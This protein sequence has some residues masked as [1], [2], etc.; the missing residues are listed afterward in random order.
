[1]LDLYSVWEGI[2]RKKTLEKNLLD[3]KLKRCLNFF[4]LTFFGIGHM[5]GA[6]IFVVTG[7]VTKNVAGTGVILSYILAGIAAFFS[8]LCYA[9]FGARVPKAGSAY[10][11]TYYTMGEF[12]AFFVGWNILLETIIGAASVAKAWS[13]SLDALFGGAIKNGT[14]TYVGSF[15]NEWLSSYPDF[16][17]VACI[18][19]WCI[20]VALGAKIS[21]VFINILTII[22][23][24]LLTL[25]VVLG[26]YFGNTSNWSNPSKGGFLPYGLSGVIAGSASC[27]YS[28]AGFESI[29]TAGEETKNP[30]KH[31]PLA[32][33]LSVIIVTVLYVGA[34]GALTLMQPYY[35]VD[36]SAPFS[37][38]FLSHNCI[39][40]ANVVSIGALIGLSASLLGSLFSISRTA[41]AISADGLLF[42]PL[43]YINEVTQTP[44]VSIILFGIVSAILA[45]VTDLTHLVE[46]LS[47]GTLI[48]YTAVSVNLIVL[49]YQTVEMC[50]FQL[51]PDPSSFFLNDKEATD[52]KDKLVAS[53]SHEDI[54]KL[55]KQFVKVPGI[56]KIPE[57]AIAPLTV[58]LII[59]FSAAIFSVVINLRNEIIEMEWWAILLL[60]IF[61]LGLLVSYFLLS[62]HQQNTSFL[63]FQVS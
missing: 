59:I 44:L 35:E 32:I 20:F 43:A 29:T 5:V 38:V 62:T 45:F 41:Y 23:I 27:F 46:F 6:G 1:M 34:S 21:S 63:T 36:V 8:A 3:T 2:T 42:K 37:A 51:K 4:D 18:I 25:I 9:E 7:A 24:I 48:C 13:G 17:A 56:S 16:M 58:T 47:I 12:P 22:N 60:V 19:L 11:F 52:D 50:Q 31:I 57:G 15:E 39:W 40:G 53:Q 10:S 26:I 49:R 61:S 33:G 14:I 30:S 28:Y 54:G 55:K